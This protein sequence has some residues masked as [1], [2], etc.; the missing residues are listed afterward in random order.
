MNGDTQ[1][2]NE[3]K[4]SGAV[5][6]LDLLRLARSRAAGVVAVLMLAL[7]SVFGTVARTEGFQ[8]S[9]TVTF[10]QPMHPEVRPSAVEF[11][12]RVQDDKW[13]MRLEPRSGQPFDFIEAGSDGTQV[14]FVTHKEA[15]ARKNIALNPKLASTLNFATAWVYRGQILHHPHAHLANAAW[16]TYASAAYFRGRTNNTAEPVASLVGGVAYDHINPFLQEAEW[17]LEDEP[18]FTPTRVIYRSDGQVRLNGKVVGSYPPPFDKGFTNAVFEALLFTNNAGLA[19][20]KT[21]VLKVYS[22]GIGRHAQTGQLEVKQEYV[23]Q[24]RSLAA[25]P[26]GTPWVPLLPPRCVI[27]DARVK[28]EI[29]RPLVYSTKRKEWPTVD[30]VRSSSAY[31]QARAGMQAPVAPL[32]PGR[33]GFVIVVLAF[34]ALAPLVWLWLRPRQVLINLKKA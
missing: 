8:V 12:L 34:A 25:L 15:S 11:S 14:Y 23:V 5:P 10:S 19:V 18:P 1:E 9:G 4:K 16:L 28:D 6:L 7:T 31:S 3:D 29:G 21:A 17:L 32:A 24:L 27:S 2:V 30:Q 13:F 33:R 26:A 20:P 22:A